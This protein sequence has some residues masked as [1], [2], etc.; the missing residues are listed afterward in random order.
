MVCYPLA[1]WTPKGGKKAG[2]LLLTHPPRAW[3]GGSTGYLYPSSPKSGR[4]PDSVAGG[5]QG[6]SV[7]P[8][9][10]FP[11]QTAPG[12]DGDGWVAVLGALAALARELAGEQGGCLPPTHHPQ[13]GV[14]L[15]PFQPGNKSRV[16]VSLSS[17]AEVPPRWS[18]VD[19]WRRGHDF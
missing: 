7:P 2:C 15:F 12:R 18:C 19:S 3:T 8:L 11:P 5:R 6:S 1:R 17:P 13:P 16:C 9:G 14:A 10:G 4:C